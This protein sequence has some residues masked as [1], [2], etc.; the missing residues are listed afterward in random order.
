ME[1]YISHPLVHPNKVEARLYQQLLAA[2]VLKKGNTMIVAPTALGKTIVAAL[3]AADRLEKIPNSKVL[4]VAPSKPLVVQHEESFREFLNLTSTSITGAIK[5]EERAK[6]WDES[7]IICATPQTVESDLINNRYSLKD[8]SLMVFDECH[9]GVGSYAYVYLASRYL[10]EAQTPLVLGLTASPGSDKDKIKCV[11]ENLFIQEVI[12]KN[13]EDTDVSPYFNPIEVEWVKVEMGEEQKRIKEHLDKALKQR[14]KLLKSMEVLPTISVGKKDL[15]MARGRVQNRIARSTTPPKECFRAISLIAASINVQHALELLETQGI[16]TLQQYFIRLKKKNTKA[17]KGLM[18]DA[19]FA[20]AMILTKKAYEMGVEHPKL[21]KLIKILQKE[22]KNGESRVI[23]FTQYR[24]TLEQIFQRCEKENINAVK[25]FGQGK[26]NGEKGLTQKEQK[27]IIKAFRMGTYDVLLSTSVAEEGIDI[28]SVDL[29]VLYEPVPSEIRMIQRRG[30]TGRKNTGKMKVLITKGTRDEG[31]YWSSIHKEKKMKEQ[32]GDASAL[33]NLE[34]KPLH[35]NSISPKSIEIDKNETGIN[36]NSMNSDS[37][38][39]S[40][41]VEGVK[42]TQKN[43][44]QAGPLKSKSMKPVIY[45]DSREGNSRVL[46]E[47]TKLGVEIEIKTMAVADYQITDELGIERKTASDFVSSIADKRLYKQA[48][49]MVEEFEKP[50]IILEGDN[51]YSGF[52]NPNAIRGALAAVA[53]DFGIPIIPTRSPDDTAAMIRRIAIREQADERPPVQV[54]TERKP[55]TLLEQKLFIV[56]S[57]P[58]VG[59]VNARKLLEEFGSVKNIINA[60]EDDLQRVDGIGKK[61]A[62]SIKKVVEGELK[63]VKVDEEKKLIN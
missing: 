55:L 35:E 24:D 52:M 39:K 9:R 29:V 12:V 44:N 47:L 41:E 16:S 62:K 15:L 36:D 49:E 61:I 2:D 51:L 20:P 38:M 56:E 46:R 32:L 27:K 63:R 26:S 57:L 11:C 21:N 6:R 33:K 50:V 40:S 54:R 17:A 60:S 43:D 14:L 30:R 34:I 7:Q 8:V 25:F 19:D 37:E 53:V 28:P 10:Q 23:V 3:V 1:K 18:V 58:N 48:K 31:Y 59:P 22:L 13:E 5:P 4:V 45:A 42:D